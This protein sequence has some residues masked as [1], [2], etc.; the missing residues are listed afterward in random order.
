V[1]LEYG[2]GVQTTETFRWT[3]HSSPHGYGINAQT[4]PKVLR[5]YFRAPVGRIFVAGDL[6]Q[7]EARV[8]AYLS[9]CREL[10]ECFNNSTRS[11]HLENALA[12]F[13]HAIEKDTPEYTLAKA[14][15]HGSNYREGPKILSVST[16]LPIRETKILLANYHRKRPEIHQW[17][18]EVWQT[19]KRTGKLTTC[20]GD[21]RVF[22]EA[23]S[24]FNLTGR[25]TDQ[26]WK[27]AIAWVPQTLVPHVLD[28]GL[29]ALGKLQ[30]DGMDLQFHHQGHDSF[31]CSIPIG[32]ERTFF[33]AVLPIY[34]GI[35]LA[36]PGGEY[37][38]PQEYA[39]GYSF[40]DMFGY[41]G[42]CLSMGAWEGL[43]SAKLAK[44]SRREQI[45]A[46]TY[47]VHLANW[48]A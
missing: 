24:C 37:T 10:I 27:D 43:V 28:I 5:Y 41:S 13:G 32:E 26:H 23:I 19:I 14:V 1:R 2:I 44:K 25:M 7:A 18:D 42:A 39:T 33:D 15:V 11:V 47:G 29:I 35:K 8:V 40:G 3:M 6:S 34:S 22:Y 46:G 16:G 17:H 36:S 31:L 30:T 20:L 21:E 45:L 12:V 9:K 4:I 48:R 38:I